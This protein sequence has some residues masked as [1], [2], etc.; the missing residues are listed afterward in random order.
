M[1][2][3][4]AHPAPTMIRWGAVIAGAIIGLA[5]LVLLTSFFVALGSEADA[6]GRNLHWFG[7]AS[8]VVALFVAG[9][10]AG[11]LSGVRGV[12]SGLFH[13][14]TAWAL[15]LAVTLAFPFPQAAGLLETFAT[16]LPD[17]EAGPL[18]AA[19]LSVLGGL[20]VAAIGGLLGGAMARPAAVETPGPTHEAEPAR[21]EPGPTEPARTEPART[22]QPP[23][24]A[25]RDEAA[26]R[27]RRR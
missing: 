27:G 24:R 4:T 16:P 13:G 3:T 14:L 9:L 11:G 6:I 23:A 20:I 8:A 21:T 1:A 15:I 5:V 17:L 22:E 7:L 19:F 12:G 25:P 10:L 2:T 26:P 18:W